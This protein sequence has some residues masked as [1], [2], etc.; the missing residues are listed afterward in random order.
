L[1]THTHQH[2]VFDLHM[3]NSNLV[4]YS[5]D[6]DQFHYLWAARRC[7]PLL[8]HSSGL[9][10]VSIE[11]A[12]TSESDN[13]PAIEAGEELID[14]AEYYGSENFERANSIKYYQLKHSTQY[15]DFPWTASGLEN[16]LRGFAER[17][18]SL[19]KKYSADQCQQ[20]LHFYFVSNRP[21]STDI[22]ETVAEVAAGALISPLKSW[23]KNSTSG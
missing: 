5:R 12:S 15:P 9:V 7:L 18:K 11:G 1:A 13:A 10:A 21:I 4:R 17:Y 6:G 22:L 2:H 8:S 20:K 23:T 16:T 14:I 19:C 3:S